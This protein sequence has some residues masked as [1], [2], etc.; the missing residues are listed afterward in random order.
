MTLS[1][2]HGTQITKKPTFLRNGGRYPIFAIRTSS[3]LAISVLVTDASDALLTYTVIDTV[4]F[5]S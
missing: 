4:I 3:T 1:T 2:S 5:E